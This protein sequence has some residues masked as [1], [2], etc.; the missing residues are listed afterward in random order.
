MKKA[1]FGILSLVAVFGILLVGCSQP[2]PGPSPTPT[3]AVSPAQPTP[4][5]TATPVQTVSL[6]K[7]SFAAE[8]AAEDSSA[9]PQI[10]QYTLPLDTSKIEN[11]SAVKEKLGFSDP[12]LLE[13][14]GF[15]VFDSGKT[16]DVVAFY[17]GLEGKEVPVFV[18]SDSL[19]H[20]YHIQ[21]DET[22]KEIEEKEFFNDITLLSRAML[23]DSMKKY[24]SSEGDLKEAAKRN[25]AFF[26]VGL[27]LL[28]PTAEI[29]SYVQADVDKEIE[30]IEKHEGFAKSQ[31]FVYQE[32]YSQYLPRGHYTRS[33]NLKKYFK[34]LMWYGRM[35]FLLK[36]CDSPECIVSEYD[37]KIQTMEALLIA[38][39]LQGVSVEGRKASDIWDRM[40]DVTAFYVGLA[41]DLT[42]YEYM[43]AIVT[44]F[45]G[46][47]GAAELAD[48]GKLLE[49][50]AEL[51]KMRSPLIY[52]GTGN[53]EVAPPVTN[54]KLNEVLE[55]T[56]GM[57]LMGQRFI[58][59]SYMFQRLV[60]MGYTGQGNPFT[61]AFSGIR[62]IR[63][64]PRGLDV[65]A[66]FGSDRELEII[67]AEGDA[68][69]KEVDE[70]YNDRVNKL[71][72]EFNAIGENGWNQN[73]YWSWLYSIKALLGDY[74]EG[75]PTF[76]QGT[77]W[78]DKQLNAA[79]GSWAQLRHDTILYAKQ[80]YTMV[81][82]AM[83]VEKEAVGYVEPVPEFYARL[84][85]LNEMTLK[86]LK[87]RGVLS[88]KAQE[89]IESLSE[90]LKRV[91]DLSKQELENKELGKED[92][93]FI[94]SFGASLEWAVA[95]L[96][97]DE[98]LE[99]GKET[100][101]IAD[102]HT[103]TPE[104]KVLEEGTGYLR[105]MVVAYKVPD[106]RI[107]LGAGPVFSYH[108]FKWPMNDR[109]TDEKWKEML[110]S[111]KEPEKPKWIESFYSG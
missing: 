7:G 62:D 99:K 103:C 45:G 15:M 8:Y 29:P 37:A 65:M 28:N 105:T 47:A 53:I 23:A 95:G 19:L 57:R 48:E 69:Y 21:F 106:G 30:L 75:Y 38:G 33:E 97:Y 16:D 107:L 26:S 78:K 111:G 51:A 20:L 91:L 94:K 54:E 1:V 92:Y 59:D 34:A 18:T 12:S 66:V 73:L 85:A 22:L 96:D 58:P 104:G 46:G 109:L 82:T 3:P 70:T 9:S 5:P 61:K 101:I 4:Q 79:L 86:G 83:P 50:K 14:N 32:D 74:G 110:A 44:V 89:R 27:K 2:G 98:E 11:Y 36:G 90:I 63:G 39:S 87:E 52:G 108:E 24:D 55:D 67:E 72:A 80:S 13:K 60:N 41:D 17:K 88:E 68:D 25:A 35:S 42:P 84:L 31:I 6:K 76:M 100:T 56:K 40:Y 49:V 93:A 64:Y 102:V 77:T 81:E 10:E 71:K 43:D